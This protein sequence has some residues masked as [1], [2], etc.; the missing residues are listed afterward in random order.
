M[1][2]GTR[3]NPVRGTRLG[4]KRPG[5]DS[6][7]TSTNRAASTAIVAQPGGD[8]P[9]RVDDQPSA[10]WDLATSRAMQDVDRTVRAGIASLTGGLAPLGRPNGKFACLADAPGHSALMQ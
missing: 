5:Q 6:L 7:V 2:S 9:T 10:G 8:P 3:E 4:N 1:P